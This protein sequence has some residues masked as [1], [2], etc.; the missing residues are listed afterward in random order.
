MAYITDP[1]GLSDRVT[2][3]CLIKGIFS[4]SFPQFQAE[5]LPPNSGV[6]SK[7]YK[8]TIECPIVQFSATR[9]E[10]VRKDLHDVFSPPS[11]S[12]LPT[13]KMESAIPPTQENY[14][15]AQSSDYHLQEVVEE[16][17]PQPSSSCNCLH[18]S[19]HWLVASI[20]VARAPYFNS[21]VSDACYSTNF[22]LC[23]TSILPTSTTF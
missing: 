11:H 17:I 21:T 23:T 18:Q 3:G 8:V 16:F 9:T 5:E 13:D 22:I 10:D 7:T 12:S 15:R 6:N 1:S 4:W 2:I 20:R 19:L 14:E